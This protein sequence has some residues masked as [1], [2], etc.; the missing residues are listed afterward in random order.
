MWEVLGVIVGVFLLGGAFA[1][2]HLH[3]KRAGKD[4]FTVPW[5]AGALI[6][7]GAT[8]AGTFLFIL[9]LG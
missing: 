9:I 6:L 2:S 7:I 1:L 5:W 4:T 3:G 8:I